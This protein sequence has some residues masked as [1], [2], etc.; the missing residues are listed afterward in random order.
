MRRLVCAFLLSLQ[1]IQI[2]CC[3]LSPLQTACY[4]SVLNSKA[5]KKALHGGKDLRVLNTI[6]GAT[7]P[8]R[9]A[10]T[11]PLHHIDASHRS[12]TDA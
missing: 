12:S 6:M 9:N 1:T 5:T 4:E 7:G 11:L 10:T 3:P 2:V 8:A